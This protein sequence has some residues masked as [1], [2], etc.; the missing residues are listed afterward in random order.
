VESRG[1]PELKALGPEDYGRCR[2]VAGVHEE[3]ETKPRSEAVGRR[4]GR[5]AL[6][7]SRRVTAG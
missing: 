3:V 2:R 5:R 6:G 4:C 7:I 1:E